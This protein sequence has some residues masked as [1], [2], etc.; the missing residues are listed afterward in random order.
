M[1]Q[2]ETGKREHQ[3]V[4][5]KVDEARRHLLPLRHAPDER[6]KLVAEAPC[7]AHGHEPEGQHAELLVVDDEPHFRLVESRIRRRVM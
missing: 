4:E 1:S 7:E 3:R 2:P 6:G 5:A